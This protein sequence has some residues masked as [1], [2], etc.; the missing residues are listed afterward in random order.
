VVK[1]KRNGMEPVKVLC[2]WP[3]LRNR[4]GS[5]TGCKT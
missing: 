1:G 4:D 3:S 2:F 5:C